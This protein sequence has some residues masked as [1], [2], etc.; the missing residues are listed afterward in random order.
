[1][2][3]RL[4]HDHD[5]DQRAIDRILAYLHRTKPD[6][7]LV[8]PLEDLSKETALSPTTAASVM[9]L[10]ECE[11]PYTVQRHGAASGENRWLVR[12]PAYDLGGWGHG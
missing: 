4:S 5:L 8:Y 1:V 11:G 2:P 3:S 6:G 12:A 9:T 7:R 10:P